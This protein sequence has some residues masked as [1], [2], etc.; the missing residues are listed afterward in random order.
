MHTTLFHGVQEQGRSGELVGYRQIKCHRE[1]IA[2]EQLP[3]VV[4]SEALR[5]IDLLVS[6]S[7]LAR[8]EKVY[9]AGFTSMKEALDE[10][11][12][13]VE[14]YFAGEFASQRL[15]LGGHY[16]QIGNKRVHLTTGRV[17]CRGK[18][19]ILP[20]SSSPAGAFGGL[21]LGEIIATLSRLLSQ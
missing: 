17:M 20:S 15:Q 11:K 4:L 8:G 3:A 16:V 12:V 19:V 2:E 9:E 13:C 6:M 10:R 18:P 7:A 14:Q 1:R 21:L 5:A